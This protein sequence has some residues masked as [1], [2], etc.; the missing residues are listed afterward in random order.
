MTR[1]T[2]PLGLGILR[3]RTERGWSRRELALRARVNEMS[4]Y[5]WEHQECRLTSRSRELV[6]HAFDLTVAEFTEIALMTETPG[7]EPGWL[8][9]Q[10]AKNADEV[11]LWPGWMRKEAAARAQREGRPAPTY[12][13]PPPEER[14]PLLVERVAALQVENAGLATQRDF[15]TAQVTR[16]QDQAAEYD[17]NRV[18]LQWRDV[19]ITEGWYWY[20]IGTSRNRHGPTEVHRINGTLCAMTGDGEGWKPCTSFRRRWAGPL[21]VPELPI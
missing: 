1:T 16:L 17:R 7:L 12:R 6:A 5:H 19:P 8:N 21:P 15:L 20:L 4:I 11:D 2:D 18:Q 3:L 13:Q 14:I 9:R 10:L